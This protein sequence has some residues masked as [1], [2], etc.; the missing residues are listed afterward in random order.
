MGLNFH[1]FR[2]SAAIRKSFIPRKFRP[3]WQ[4]VCICKTIASQNCKNGSNSIGQ[5]PY[6]DFFQHCLARSHGSLLRFLLC[7]RCWRYLHFRTSF[8]LFEFDGNFGLHLKSRASGRKMCV[9]C[10]GPWGKPT[11]TGNRTV[12]CSISECQKIHSGISAKPMASIFKSH[13]HN[14]DGHLFLQRRW[15]LFCTG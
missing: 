14:C 8:G 11:L 4:Q 13:L 6:N 5:L 12:T 15:P 9:C 1:G 7:H 10:G 3:V 2:G